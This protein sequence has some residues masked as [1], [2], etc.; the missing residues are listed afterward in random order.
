MNKAMRTVL[1]LSLLVLSVTSAFAAPPS[2]TTWRG[3]H[4]GAI[5]ITFDDGYIS[6]Y[7]LAV[8][9]LNVRGLRGTFF[10]VSSFPQP[11]VDPEFASWDNWRTV[12]SMG[13]EIG[14]HTVTHSDLTTLSLSAAENELSASQAAINTQIPAQNCVTFA[15]PSGLFNADVEVLVAKYYIAARGIVGAL[16]NS[17]TDPYDEAGYDVSTYTVWEM[18]NLADQAASQGK[19]LVPSFHS[20]NPA[21]WGT[22]SLDQFTSYLDYLITRNLWIAPF[23]EVFKYQKERGAATLSVSSQ[24]SSQITLNLTE[25]LDTNLYNYPLT[26]RSEIPINWSSVIMRQG[27]SVAILTPVVEG[28]AW[29]VYCDA[30]PGQG[31]ITLTPGGT[32]LPPVANNDAYSTNVNTPLTVPA[33]GVLANDTDPQGASLTALLVSG[34]SHGTLTLNSNR[35]FSYT[36][37]SNYTGSDSFSYRAS[38]G[39]LS[40]GTARAS[41]TVSALPPLANNDNYNTLQNNAL[42]VAAPGV[43]GND[44]DPQGS[45]LTAHLVSGPSHGKLT[46]NANG[47]F[48]YTPTTNYTGSD[49]FSYTANDRTLSSSAATVTITVNATLALS[50]LALNQVTVTG[51]GASQGTVALD[52]PAPSGG[53]LVSL[54]GNSSAIALPASL[55]VPAGSSSASFS[56]GSSPVTSSTLVTISALYGGVTKTASLTVNAPNLTAF[57]LSPAT[58]TGGLTSQ[59]TVTLDGAAPAGGVLVS[60]SDDSS[61]SVVPVSV[62]V[63]GGSASASFAMTTTPVASLTAVAVTA[64]CAGV[65]KFAMLTLNPPVLSSLTLAPASVTGGGTSQGTVTL[66]G[67]APAGGVVLTLSSNSQVAATPA[68]VTVPSGSASASFTISTTQVASSSAVTVSALYAGVTKT[69]SLT[70]IPAAAPVLSTITVNP[71]S[72][73]GGVSS[74][75]TVTL[76]GPAPTGGVVVTLSDNSSAAAEPASVTVAAGSSSATF[77]VTTTVVTSS[78]SVTVSAVNNGVTRTAIL[79]VTAAAGGSSSVSGSISPA[80]SGAGATLT[81]TQGTA[82]VATVTAASDGSFSFAS[83][84]NGSYTVTPAKPGFSFSPASAPVTVNGANV[85]GIGFAAAGLAIDATTSSDRSTNGT[86]IAT[87]AFSTGAG[88]ELLLA[89][90]SCDASGATPNVTV[91]GMSGAGLSWT[92]V[93]RTN[94]QFGTAEIW[95]AFATGTLS[96]ATVTATLS[97]SIPASIT[98]VT[99]AGVNPTTP[100]GAVGSGSALTGAPT[101]SLTTQ[102]A[103]SW[104]FGVG[105]DWYGQVART[106]GGNQALVHQYLN[107]DPVYGV[108]DTFW[109]QRQNATVQPAGTVVTINDSAPTTDGWNLSLVE[110]LAASASNSKA[111]T[112]SL[113]PAPSGAR[114]T[115]TLT[116]GGATV[117]TVTAAS[118]GSFSFPA[119][120]NG[121]YTVTPAKSGFSFTPASTPV[122]VNGADV[123]GINFTVAGLAV[124]LT[125]STDRGTNGTSIATPSFSTRVGNELLLAF[126]ASDATGATP[127]VTVTGVSG[128]G[129]T[130]TLVQRSNAQFGTAEIW[131]AFA[132]SP[133][134][135][136]TVSA[137]L[138]QNIPASIT[139]VA[140]AGVNASAPVGTTGAG[141]GATGAP[142]ASLTTQGANSLVCGVGNDWYGQIARTP[143]ANQTLVH[144]Y[145]NYDPVYGVV[146]TF[147]VQCQNAT[148]QP[149]GTV[150]TINDSAPTTD[151][152]NLS[153]VEIRQ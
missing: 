110:I 90:V 119:V 95:R 44:S 2:I 135:G 68:S 101:A 26:L 94:A 4:A 37:A 121:S 111:V 36:P 98:V 5:S 133:I 47:S 42:S 104:V 17:V 87:P 116:Q 152:W 1:M 41:I 49:S 70:V 108:V 74:L 114:A 61:S 67:P 102:G 64:A 84:A 93:Q 27:T 112:G 31:A 40:S 30:V 113:S 12:A 83:L 125:V 96:G 123:T 38:N 24:T 48:A 14:S 16:N 120:A 54:S 86:T 77:T 78:T 138:S 6:Q 115:V 134:S 10:V 147:W 76:S 118:D 140:F 62:T 141:S 144:Q 129:L 45:S 19:W 136:A 148:V 9:A 75:G 15:Y 85:T 143:G 34:P 137:S 59:G 105:N 131:S 71:T 146:D 25:S 32:N 7:T 35:S 99:Y 33:P 28:S 89:F 79:N 3:N 151:G 11:P 39:P 107:Y 13:H 65:T 69:A 139:L 21:E 145:L 63:P 92:L 8:P 43:L 103:N 106:P 55:T 153:L 97:Q 80:P 91:T 117:A 58:V 23:G 124:D 126:V 29:V 20:F 128:A 100:V 53:V 52:G 57:S 132:S 142:S 60:V 127:N 22:W 51:G 56:I 122:T 50:S 88:N 130:W 18:E 46:L 73:T 66:S 82:T 150:V 81:L 109:V 72:V 149:A